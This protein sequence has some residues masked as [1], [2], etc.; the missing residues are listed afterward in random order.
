[1][2]ELIF[3]SASYRDGMWSIFFLL[4]YG[5]KRKQSLISVYLRVTKDNGHV[6]YSGARGQGDAIQINFAAV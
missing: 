2:R 5:G 1:M 3:L 4:C 6:S